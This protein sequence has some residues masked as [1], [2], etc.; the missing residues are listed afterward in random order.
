MKM[1]I[2]RKI[3]GLF[4]AFMLLFAVLFV[5]APQEEAKA[6]VIDDI[7]NN[8]SDL[9]LS[10]WIMN[11][12]L[13][14]YD[15][16]NKLD[17]SIVLSSNSNRPFGSFSISYDFNNVPETYEVY[18][19]EIDFEY[20]VLLSSM[21][22]V[23]NDDRI[24][25][26]E[27][28]G[29]VNMID[30]TGPTNR[31]LAYVF[32]FYYTTPE[33]YNVEASYFGEWLSNH[34]RKNIIQNYQ[35]EKISTGE[36]INFYPNYLIAG[37]AATMN[38]SSLSFEN[39]VFDDNY[40]IDFGS[41]IG[42]VSLYSIYTIADGSYLGGQ[43][44]EWSLVLGKHSASNKYILAV[45]A[46]FD[47]V[48]LE[49]LILWDSFSSLNW[50]S[51]YLALFSNAYATIN[52]VG[53]QNS[54]LSGFISQ[55]PIEILEVNTITIEQADG[56]FEVIEYTDSYTLNSDNEFLQVS[57]LREYTPFE[58]D[59]EIKYVEVFVGWE[60]Q[61]AGAD[62][63][64]D[65]TSFPVTFSNAD[66]IIRPKYER[67][68]YI[69]FAMGIWIGSHPPKTIYGAIPVINNSITITNNLSPYSKYSLALG[70]ENV[71]GLYTTLG[72]YN[73]NDLFN[74]VEIVNGLLTF[75]SNVSNA[76]LISFEV[77]NTVDGTTT[78]VLSRGPNADYVDTISITEISVLS[79]RINV[80]DL[81]ASDGGIIGDINVKS[82]FTTFFSLVG[83][84]LSMKLGF[85]T[86]GEI[87]GLVLAIAL[88]G[89]IFKVWNGGNNG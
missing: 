58:N 16:D 83:G 44:L 36:N 46:Y 71:Q 79:F 75:S 1:K 4:L 48:T 26:T 39:I 10:S 64:L 70:E 20:S 24:L 85:I 59:L 80:K 40:Q 35:G 77:Q 51:E 61:S 23:I 76:N 52:S 41:G 67:P 11:E 57:E 31:G 63:W 28:G 32:D 3:S 72:I 8:W 42:D 53:P 89:F 55:G 87:I 56:S 60:Y 30:F 54:I 78:T 21:S 49:K 47:G 9:E 74:N 14:K 17:Y 88:L 81:G 62:N 73:A 13:F 12:K 7:Y 34:A 29:W 86:L 27:F 38:M 6:N 66:Y 84:F 69:P 15:I 33:E 50:N 45:L 82:A 65:I 43:V 68:P 2:I 5:I 37:V 25:Y 19:L 22:L 18:K